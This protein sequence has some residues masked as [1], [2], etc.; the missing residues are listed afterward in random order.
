MSTIHQ[1]GADHLIIQGSNTWVGLLDGNKLPTLE[2]FYEGISNALNF[3]D[4]FGQNLDALDEL[5]FD[6][7][8]IRQ[9][10]VLLIIS[11]SAQ[12]LHEDTVRKPNLMALLS[13]VENPALEIIL[14]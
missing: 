2:S 12:L 11:N 14:L 1:P 6:M 7:D 4:Y 8:W 10:H 3:P 9:D 13:D 5:L